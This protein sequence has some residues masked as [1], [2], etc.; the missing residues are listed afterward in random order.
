MYY[1]YYYTVEVVHVH[2]KKACIGLEVQLHS[3]LTSALD[4][5]KWPT[6]DTGLFNIGN[7]PCTH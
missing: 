2:G 5:V 3:F 6:L 4:G 1:Y 7:N